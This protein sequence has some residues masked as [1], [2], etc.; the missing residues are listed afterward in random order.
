MKTHK[1]QQNA[2]AGMLPTQTLLQQQYQLQSQQH[3]H[4]QLQQQLKH[5]Q[6]PD[7]VASAGATGSQLD[8]HLSHDMMTS[9]A[10]GTQSTVTMT[11]GSDVTRTSKA[12]RGQT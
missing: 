1:R 5:L 7:L 11:P 8:V 4:Q 12:K 9:R 3:L 2:A 10:S 6:H